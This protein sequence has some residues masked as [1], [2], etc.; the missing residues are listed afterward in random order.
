MTPIRS[1]SFSGLIL[2]AVSVGAPAQISPHV[3]R[4]TDWSSHHLVVSGGPSAANLKAA[5]AEPR[6]LCQ[7]C[8]FFSMLRKIGPKTWASRVLV[9]VQSV[10]G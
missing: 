8:A 1:L 4:V 3:G 6:I 9:F 10:G 7:H 2:A 5:E